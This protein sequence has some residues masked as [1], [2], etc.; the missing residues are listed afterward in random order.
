MALFL[1]QKWEQMQERVDHWSGRLSSLSHMRGEL[2]DMPPAAIV[3]TLAVALKAVLVANR[4]VDRALQELLSGQSRFSQFI[5]LYVAGSGGVAVY[6]SWATITRNLTEGTSDGDWLVQLMRNLKGL[7]SRF[8]Y[9]TAASCVVALHIGQSSWEFVLRG[10]SS[11]VQ[12]RQ[13]LRLLGFGVIFAAI[14]DKVTAEEWLVRARQALAARPSRD[15]TVKDT[16]FR[17]V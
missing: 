2:V 10:I 6:S 1:M 17:N 4:L 16:A 14:W 15:E 11:S 3:A 9:S 8:W 5:L 13:L 7:P 12:G